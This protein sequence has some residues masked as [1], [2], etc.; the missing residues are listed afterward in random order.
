MNA[1]DMNVVEKKRAGSRRVK[2]AGQVS[3]PPVEKAVDQQVA[4]IERTF[5]DRWEW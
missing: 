2:P 3:A 5:T 4:E 1:V